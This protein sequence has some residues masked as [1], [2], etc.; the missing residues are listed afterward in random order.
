MAT[1]GP[2]SRV[3]ELRTLAEGPK[4]RNLCHQIRVGDTDA[5][6]EGDW[7]LLSLWRR[8]VGHLPRDKAGGG[9]EVVFKMVKW[10]SQPWWG[11][12]RVLGR[13]NKWPAGQRQAEAS[14][15]GERA[16][17]AAGITAQGRLPQLCSRLWRWGRVPPGR[18]LLGFLQG[19]GAASQGGTIGQ[20][21]KRAADAGRKVL[22]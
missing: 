6:L 19:W 22:K 11:G 18:R 7:F 12:C 17:L 13:E 10:S 5:V 14:C 15:T 16:R 1:Q 3:R 9:R 2:G 8:K 4:R 20:A 21:A